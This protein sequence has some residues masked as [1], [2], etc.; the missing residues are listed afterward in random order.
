M[1]GTEFLQPDNEQI[2]HQVRGILDS[3]SHEWDLLAELLQNSV[4]AIREKNLGKG[5][6][7]LLVDASTRLIRVR[8]NGGGIDPTQISR[9]MRPFGTNKSSKPKQI[10]EKG[11]GLKFVMFSSS[12]IKLST[13]SSEGACTATVLDA[14]AWLDSENK[15]FLLLSIDP[16]THLAGM[17][18]EV[19]ITLSDPQH[20]IFNFTFTELVFLLRTRTACGDTGCIWDDALD[21]DTEFTHVDMAGMK[22]VLEFECRYL[23]PIE[24]ANKNEYVSI[25]E[26]QAWMKESDRSDTE[27]R[28]RLLNK[29]VFAKGKNRQRGER[30]QI[31]VVLCTTP[32]VLESFISEVWHYL[33]VGRG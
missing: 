27:K 15:S 30:D 26:F 31:L 16:Q 1:S 33:S 17:G 8:D 32:G 14:A 28:R 10:G 20:P 23:L 22:Q 21:A 7:S 11:V 3:Y 24:S 25:D 4:D 13:R 18:T 12:K 9:L 2:R 6:I 29:I 19:E 5:H